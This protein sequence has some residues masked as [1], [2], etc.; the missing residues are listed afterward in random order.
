MR[1]TTLRA[2]QLYC[3]LFWIQGKTI[4]LDRREGVILYCALF[5]IQG[6]TCELECRVSSTLYCALFWIQGKTYV[7]FLSD[8]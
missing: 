6:K 2:Y 3:A 8:M 5:W 7:Y 4:I 1:N